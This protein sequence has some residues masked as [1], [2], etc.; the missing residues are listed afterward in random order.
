MFTYVQV[1][2]DISTHACQGARL[3]LGIFFSVPPCSSRQSLSNP[4]L[5]G[6]LQGS[7]FLPTLELQASCHAP[8]GIYVESGALK[9][10]SLDY[11]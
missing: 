11:I 3:I 9:S 4:E 6:L 2:T 7:Q 5:R 1:H 8:S 10:S